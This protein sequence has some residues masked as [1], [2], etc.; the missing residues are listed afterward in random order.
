MHDALDDG[1]E[2]TAARDRVQH[3]HRD[4]FRL[5]RNADGADAVV[6]STDGAHHMRA[7]RAAAGVAVGLPGDE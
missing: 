7:V 5:R 4:Q 2:R 6:G 3:L 1:G